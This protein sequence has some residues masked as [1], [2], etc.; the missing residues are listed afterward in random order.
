MVHPNFILLTEQQP[1]LP[2]LLS[3]QFYS[4]MGI[5]LN[6]CTVRRIQPWIQHCIKLSNMLKYAE[7]NISPLKSAL[8]THSVTLVDSRKIVPF[9]ISVSS[10]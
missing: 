5:P 2:N 7:N 3:S 9:Q 6:V 4:L 10:F 8:K 1:K